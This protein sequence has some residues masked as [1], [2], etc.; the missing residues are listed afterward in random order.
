MI[1]QK[2]ALLKNIE[3][4]IYEKIEEA[5]KLCEADKIIDL[6]NRILIKPNYVIVEKEPYIHVT[7]PRIIIALIE[8]LKN[9]DIKNICIS[10]GG[11][12][13]ETAE[14]AFKETGLIEVAK[15]YNVK[16]INLNKDKFITI[17]IPNSFNLKEVNIAKT[18]LESDFI[19]NVS[20]LKVHHIAGVTLCVKN[21]MGCIWPKNIIHEKIQEKLADLA[22]LIKTKINIID[23]IIGSEEDEIYGRPIKMDIIIAG[24]NIVA[25]DSIGCLSMGINPEKVKYLKLLEKEGLGIAR[26]ESIKVLGERI[27]R[28]FKKFKLPEKFMDWYSNMEEKE[29]E[30]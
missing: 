23:G 7:D 15:K 21:L 10:E 8:W 17:K 13:V 27:D 2:V 20:K 3:E 25:T 22:K 16:L 12:S 24:L 11:W 1:E 6:K 19:I 29:N 14:N 30:M 26:K 28:V 5:L 18:I 9:R 4:N